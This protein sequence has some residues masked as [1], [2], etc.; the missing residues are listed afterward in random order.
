MKN[1]YLAAAKLVLALLLSSCGAGPVG[2]GSGGSGL[3][4]EARREAE[5]YWDSALTKCG[6]SLYGV[7]ADTTLPE[8]ALY[9][10]KDP[11]ITVREQQLSDA[12][13]LNGLEY[14]AVTAVTYKAFRKNWRGEWSAW[15]GPGMVGGVN[16][17]LNEDVRKLKGRWVVGR[18]PERPPQN[19]KKVDCS[20]VPQ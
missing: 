4:A 20:Q 15:Q 6:D 17:Y 13:R 19:W 10:F 9:Q 7:K 11:E 3:A 14:A 5:K 16:T 18:D 1:Y 8:G 12:G 2:P